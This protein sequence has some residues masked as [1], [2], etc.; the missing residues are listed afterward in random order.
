[1]VR[2]FSR[3]FCELPWFP[4]CTLHTDDVSKRGETTEFGAY[5]GV[6]PSRSQ[7]IFAGRGASTLKNWETC[8]DFILIP[9]NLV[10]KGMVHRGFQTAW[11][12]IAKDVLGAIKDALI[13]FPGYDIVFAGESM[14]G[15]VATLGAANIRAAGYK[16]DLYTFGSPRVGNKV[17]VDFIT[18]QPGARYRVTHNEDPV[19]RLPPRKL[20]P[21]YGHISP[22]YW[23]TGSP[24]NPDR[25]PVKN[26]KV[27][28]GNANNKCNANINNGQNMT[29][30]THYLGSLECWKPG[31]AHLYGVS[32]IPPGITEVIIALAAIDALPS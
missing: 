16:V 22:E 20:F 25:W 13:D 12:E 8:I 21:A 28:P 15:A 30:H 6:I 2:L 26:I 1:M 11:E 19:P 24:A 18:K 10:A 14:G 29:D 32:S 5:L 17:L 4:Y 31:S 9:N 3:L 7:I 27:C 23:L